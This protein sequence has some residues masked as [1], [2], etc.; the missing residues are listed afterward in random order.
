MPGVVEREST[1]IDSLDE[2]ISGGFPQNSSVLLLGPPGVGKTTFLNQFVYEGLEEGD[3]VLYITL[4]NPPE[5]VKESASYFGWGFDEYS[6]ELVFIDGYS[7]REGKEPDGKFAIEGPSDLNQMNMTLADAMTELGSG[8]KRIVMDSV[9]T[10]VLYTDPTSAVKFLQMV[11]AK[12]KASNGTLVMT[13]E[14]GVHDQ[15]TISTLNYVADGL[16]NM[17]M[18]EDRRRISV[19]R[20]V[21]TKHSR[22]WHDFTIDREEGISLKQEVE[23]EA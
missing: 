3:N 23:V 1:G 8:Q 5:E 7:W 11:G 13:L 2:M 16:I 14:E 19:K 21:K 17:E 4:D 20:M 10:L 15:K 18:E 6:D 9:S 22:E 12:S